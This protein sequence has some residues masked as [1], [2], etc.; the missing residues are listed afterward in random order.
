MKISFHGAA[1][2]VTGSKHLLELEDGTHI[3]LD[4]GMFQGNPV[5]AA[6]LNRKFGFNPHEIDFLL[7]SHAHID[8]CGLIPKLVKGGFKGKIYCTPA[9]LDL[10][11]ILLFDSAHIQ[12]S[13]ASFLNKHRHKKGEAEIEPLY[14]L[15]DVNAAL[16]YFIPVPINE[17]VALTPRAHFMYTDVGHI[18]GSTAINVTILE[19]GKEIRIAFSGDVG[20]YNDEILH[21]PQPFPQADYLILESTYGDRLHDEIK[22]TDIKLLETIKQT[23]AVN[24]GKLVIPAFS[25]GRTQEIVYALNRLQITNQLPDIDFF[26]DSPLSVEATQV[27]KAHSECYNDKLLQFMKRD[28]EPFDFKR[29]HYIERVE[30]S[31]A[32]NSYNG[33]CVIISSSG[34]ADAGRVKHHIRNIIN[35]ARN[36]I[37]LVGYCEPRSLGGKL[38]A[39]NKEITI[40]GDPYE[41][42]A[43]IETIRSLSAH[44]DYEDLLKF[45]SCQKPELIK[46]LFLVHGEYEVQ[47]HF[48]EK[49]HNAGFKNVVIPAMHQTYTL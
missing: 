48:E 31:K 24:K 35:D 32:L 6:A 47:K 27:I 33:P 45:I 30:D 21:A 40:F 14:T 38:M 22:Q 19:D 8:H 13:D 39:G 41:V 3:L 12:Q 23:C 9:T 2:C 43:K 34:M 20:R 18:L 15:D 46:T 44:G 7:L 29:L 25:V 42:K 36:C 28:P 11:K 5:E 1:Q 16:E 26:V 37:L 49:L 4:C 17:K 10:A